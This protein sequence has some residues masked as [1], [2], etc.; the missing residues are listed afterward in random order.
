[1]QALI[2]TSWD[3][4]HPA[5]SRVAEMLSRYGLTGTFYIPRKIE[6]GVMPDQEIRNLAQ[7]FE[8]G[9][10]TLNHVFLA[11]ADDAT[12]QSEIAGSKKWV[13]DVTGCRCPMFCPPAGRFR[14]SHLPMFREAGFIAFRSVE[15]MSFDRPRSG[16]N[17]LLEMPTTMQAFPQPAWGYAKNVAKRKSVGGMWRLLC[18]AGSTRDWPRLVERLLERALQQGGVFHL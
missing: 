2:T 3:D 17:Q 5:D 18:N 16:M 14:P 8:I 15:F 11:D 9:A 4:G 6:T 7:R 1:M 10:H 13:E 12:A